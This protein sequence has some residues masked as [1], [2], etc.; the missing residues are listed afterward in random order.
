[1]SQPA[2]RTY[3]SEQVHQCANCAEKVCP[4]GRGGWVHLNRSYACQD[5]AR[6]LTGKYAWPRPPPWVV[7]Q[8]M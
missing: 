7:G 4:D 3:W 2:G 1:M 5:H 6:E 8:V